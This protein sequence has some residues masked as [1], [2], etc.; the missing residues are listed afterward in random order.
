MVSLGLNELTHLPVEK[1]LIFWL[2]FLWSL[3][4]RTWYSRCHRHW[5]NGWFVTCLLMTYKMYH[6][7]YHVNS[8]FPG[9]CGC[10]FKC[11]NFKHKLGIDI[12]S[13]QVNFTLEWLPEDLVDCKSTSDIG[14]GN[15]LVPHGK[16]LTWTNVDPNLC[17]HMASLGYN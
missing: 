14:S 8:S 10:N 2:K 9:R 12:L 17:H 5:F 7:Y 15:G 16:P 13:I 4:L 11:I 3:F 1:S 6:M